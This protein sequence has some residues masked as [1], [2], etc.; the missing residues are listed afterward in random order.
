MGLQNKYLKKMKSL[1]E[2]ETIAK[3]A[4]KATGF[5]W[6]ESE[7]IGKCIRQLEMFGLPGVK[8][9]NSYFNDKEKN[10]YENLRL[11]KESNPSSSNQYCPIILGIAFLDQQ[12][13]VE[14]Y[15]KIYISNIAYP[16]IF[17]SF[18]SRSSEIIG[19]KI[20]FKFDD[21]E[22]VLNHNVNIL[23]NLPMDDC[24]ITAQN[25]EIIFIAN[26]DNFTNQEWK[27]LYKL[28]ENTFVD[29][30]DSLKKGAA[31]AGLTDND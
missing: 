19:K 18:L 29:E 4:S 16:I 14:I 31:G 22:F 13:T 2:I 9:L 25:S 3:R 30:T 8:H 11:I 7:E 12:K 1:S 6:G 28:S 24:P 26:E 21:K 17:L 15:E 5:S 23:S 10:T 20:N 27:N